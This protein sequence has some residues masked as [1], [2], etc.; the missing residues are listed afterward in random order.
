MS[1]F[2]RLR[3]IFT[4]TFKRLL[5]QRGLT[6]ATLLGLV[7]AVALIMTVPL[8]ADA[9]YFRILEEELSQNAD[10]TNRPPFTYLYDY[11][12]SWAGPLQWEAIQPLDQYLAGQGS[13]DLGLPR[14]LLVRHL[15]TE[16]FR[17]FPADETNYNDGGLAFGV[18]NFAA[19]TGIADYIE[20]VEG[21][22]PSP[23]DPSPDSTVAVLI[24]ENLAAES[25]LQVGDN[26]IAYDFQEET[27]NP[28]QTAVQVAGIWRAADETDDFWF[29][30]PEVFDDLMLVPEE[31]YVERLAPVLDNEINRAV[32]FLVMD[33]GGVNTTNAN[34]LAARA[35]RV[36]RQTDT[37]LP[38]TRTAISPADA[39]GRYRGQAQQL[40]VLL[41]AFNVPTIGLILAFIGLI[42]GLSVGR[43]RNEIAVIRSRGGTP[44]QI[45]GFALLE[46]LVLGGIA[47]LLGTVAALGLTQLM[48]KSRSFLDFSAAS[49]LR[50]ALTTDA[51][52]AGL[53]AIVLAVLAQVLPTI[54]AAQDTII[55]YKQE[56]ARSLKRPW[57]QRAWLDVLLLIPAVYGMYLL[58]E[59]G[60]ISEL[61][62]SAAG[63]TFQN[64]LLFLIPALVV[65]SLT[66]LFL[67]F[68][69][70]IMGA[71][72]WLLAQTNSIGLL[73]AARQL[74]RM[75]RLYVM[76]LILLVLTVSL[77]VF[78]ASLA[79]T[80]DF[81]LYDE[82]RYNIGADVNLRGSGVEFGVS[83]IFPGQETGEERSRAI[84]LPLSEYEQ[85]PGVEAAAR[86]GRFN[87]E[88]Q[89][90]DQRITGTY[91]G[92][93]R[94]DFGEVAFWRWDFAPYRL[95]SL[96]NALAL[97]P[98]AILV[99]DEF[100]RQRGL[101]PGDLFRL[102]VIL[103]EGR[104]ELDSQIAGTFSYFPTW[105]PEEDG[106]LFVGN[107]E[108]LFAQIG[109]QLPYEIWLQTQGEPDAASL[110]TALDERQLFGWTWQEPYSR[111]VTEQRRPD[112]Q[113]V[114]GLLSVGFI[115]AALLTV[116]GFFMYALFSLRQRFISLGI[117]RAVGLTQ[118]HMTIFIAFEL[119]FLI[120]TGLTLGTILGTF[121]SQ[122]FIPYLQIG[123]R[124][125]DLVPPY[126][127]EIAWSAVG[128]IYLLFALM[129]VVAL[130]LLATILRRMRIFQAIKLGETV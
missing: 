107:L 29:F 130:L 72:S 123:V 117:L 105:Y 96:L 109:G 7:T 78:T 16:R 70:L 110:E 49:D 26:L 66:L 63:S 62:E 92:I 45:V 79:Q 5:A 9:V 88:A 73:M 100:A 2:Y 50:V 77:A 21:V 31:T 33:G 20:I 27:T 90:G 57:W 3:A 8:Y 59:Q 82:S 11:V 71:V 69:P 74:A 112:R 118:G 41:A 22:F 12:G 83:S 106:P 95:G 54:A 80:L 13:R 87:G 42:V 129:F 111:V 94:A 61:G 91:L 30:V 19:T 99:S 114:F 113:G 18:F 119:A 37:L 6:A 64:P 97:S 17:L 35:A 39:L 38:N 68:L 44:W 101:R 89:I 81:Q 65:F 24:S 115:A 23:A 47:T 93:D 108:N 103:T 122:Q 75:P 58:R 125:V 55:T 32:W 124:E 56:Q 102:T 120:I 104:V 46:G 25:G 4:L 34:A 40:T 43:R 76:P 36:E 126:L 86:V 84:Y 67:R 121:I 52:Q 127:V 98:D 116:L 53:A 60:T 28:R 48:G 51:W 1:F 15:E 14:D 128:E 85:F 10:R